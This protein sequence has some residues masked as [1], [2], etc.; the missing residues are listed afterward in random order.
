[1]SVTPFYTDFSEFTTGTFLPKTGWESGDAN[2]NLWQIYNS[3]GYAVLY[4]GL[5]ADTIVR[6]SGE[7]N[8]RV[9]AR[10]KTSTSSNNSISGV[11]ARWVDATH[12]ATLELVRHNGGIGGVAEPENKYSIAIRNGIGHYETVVPAD[13]Q[14]E[15][16][17]DVEL[18]MIGPRILCFVD[19]DVV[20]DKIMNS[21]EQAAIAGGTKC[22]PINFAGNANFD[23]LEITDPTAVAWSHWTG[24]IEEPLSMP[25]IWNGTAEVP[26]GGVEITT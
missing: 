9:K 24:S 16:F 13:I 4:C 7:E 18:Q 8:H 21:T 26:V 3:G 25:M 6:D 2:K 22:G 23:S 11:C 12:Y 1:M 14:W 15:T 19:G 20:L 10:L 5:S 17:Y